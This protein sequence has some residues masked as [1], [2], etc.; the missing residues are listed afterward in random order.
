MN[1]IANRLGGMLRGR[2]DKF[3]LY[4]GGILAC[5]M[6]CEISSGYSVRK[7]Q[8]QRY[9]FAKAFY[10]TVQPLRLK[11]PEGNLGLCGQGLF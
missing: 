3:N 7:G 2:N 1:W 10:G 8:V 11:G 4:F 9:C 5:E 6:H